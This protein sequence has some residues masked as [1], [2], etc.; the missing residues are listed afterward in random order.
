MNRSI[1]RCYILLL[2]WTAPIALASAKPQIDAPDT[3]EQ[4]GPAGRF[5]RILDY[6]ETGR[7]PD[8][9]GR[10]HW[11]RVLAEHKA[12]IHECE[13]HE[14]FRDALNALFT[15]S[16]VSHFSYL[17]DDDWSYWLLRAY[18]GDGSADDRIAHIGVVPQ[19]IEGSWY[20]RG[21]LEG[22]AA[23]AAGVSVGD[24]LI[25]VDGQPFSPVRSF[26]HNAGEPV[27]MRIRRHR[28]LVMNIT[29]RPVQESLH[30]ATQRATQKSIRIIDHAGLEFAYMHGWTLLGGSRD[31]DELLKLQHFVDGLILDYRD[32]FGGSPGPAMRFL[33]GV[34]ASSGSRV[35]PQWTKPVVVLTGDGTRSAKEIVVNAAQKAGRA[36]LI[37]EPTPG[38]VTSIGAVREVGTDGLLQLP[39]QILELEGR[40]T[41]PD[42]YVPREIRYAAGSDPQL[43]LAKIVLTKL[44]TQ[45]MADLETTATAP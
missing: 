21:V 8:L 34:R 15:A 22:G 25:S 38:H 32:G 18:F 24:E 36:I 45:P 2:A 12:S 28:D 40:P 20:A 11:S 37:G 13:S 44:V 42:I 33:V 43:R 10:D 31:Y 7:V 19:Q 9:V 3:F 39:G 5:S 14:S 29:L 17:I 26:R 30:K 35:A 4:I 1:P 23:A 6:I 27:A 16:G 41:Q